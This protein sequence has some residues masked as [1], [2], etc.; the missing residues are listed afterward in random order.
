VAYQVDDAGRS[1]LVDIGRK[2]GQKGSFPACGTCTGAGSLLKGF[3]AEVTGIVTDLGNG[4]TPPKITVTS[5]QGSN[6]RTGFCL[7]SLAGCNTKT[8][9]TA[10]T[11]VAASSNKNGFA[12]YDL[13][14]LLPPYCAAKQL[15]FVL[16][17]CD[18]VSMR[19]TNRALQ[20]DVTVANVALN[21][22]TGFLRSSTSSSTT[23][24]FFKAS[25]CKQSCIRSS[26]RLCF[27]AASNHEFSYIATNGA[28]H[29]VGGTFK[30]TIAV[31][32]NN[33][34][35]RTASVKCV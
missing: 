6:G 24:S 1:L 16:D 35:C 10:P 25:N 21:N 28:G 17:T 34:S 15:N 22:A 3:R 32:T 11:C 14:E 23:N 7:D 12:C 29:Q 30:T 5:A 8:A 19:K 13:A 26:N 20:G 27:N 18:G 33:K 4:S 9:V 2:L 31:K